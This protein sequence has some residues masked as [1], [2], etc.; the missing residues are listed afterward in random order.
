MS[1]TS[2]ERLLT[3]LDRGVPDRLPVTTHHLMTYFLSKYMG[4]ASSR[5]FFDRF[6]LDAIYWTTPYRPNSRRGEYYDPLEAGLAITESRRIV[7]DDWRIEQE[8]L[9]DAGY[10]TVRY[11]VITP[12][13]ILTAVAQSNEYTS[14]LSEPLVKRKQD[15]DIIGKYVIAPKCDVATVNDVS[16]QFGERGIVRGSV[17][18]FDFSGQPGC[19]QDACCLVGTE[20]MIMATYDDP[21]WVHELL[22]ILFRRKKVYIRSLKGV[23]YDIVEHGGG[24]ASTTV[25]SPKIFDKFVAPYDAPLIDLLHEVGMR[26]VYHTCG[27]MMPLLERIAD[28]KPDAMETFTPSGMG[29]DADLAAA[30][31]RIGDR[32][33]MIGGFDQFHYFVDCSSDETRAEV[34]RCFQA[35]GQNG[36]YILSPS[37][38][39]FDADPALL[40]A[41]SFAA[42]ACIYETE[43]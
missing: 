42:H 36:G 29:G 7:A 31:R 38:H 16:M 20:Q 1:M 43:S 27:G 25:I 28:M 17:C 2:R 5:E 18:G 12:G 22:G 19:W 23:R 30:K 37:D 9:P 13:G 21:D 32:V 10:R 26:V 6:D 41:Y 11:R 39:F 14:W 15:I 24:A 34:R 33:C 40:A 8:E 35:A 4:G 3:A